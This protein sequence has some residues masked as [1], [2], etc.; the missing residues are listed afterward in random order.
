MDLNAV[1]SILNLE[2]AALRFKRDLKECTDRV[3][4]GSF[5]DST[6]LRLFT[7]A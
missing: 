5:C 2:G 1:C 3:F 7:F 4:L 6:S